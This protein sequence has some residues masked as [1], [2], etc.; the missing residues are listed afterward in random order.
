MAEKIRVTFTDI[1]G[2]KH[3]DVVLKTTLTADEVIQKL[4][5]NNFLAELEP[6]QVYTLENKRTKVTIQPN[7]TLGNAAVQEGDMLITG[8]MTRGG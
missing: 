6:G 5:S 1:T 3:A 8:V 7:Q 2:S 4:R